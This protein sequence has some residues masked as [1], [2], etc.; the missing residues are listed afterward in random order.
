MLHDE[1]GRRYWAT[2][3]LSSLPYSM[4]SLTVFAERGTWWVAALRLPKLLRFPQIRSFFLNHK[5]VARSSGMSISEFLKMLLVLLGITHFSGTLWL[6]VARMERYYGLSGYWLVPWEEGGAS[7]LERYTDACFWA[8]STLTSIGFGDIAPTTAYERMFS[9]AVMVIGAS[10]YGAIFGTLV[11]LLSEENFKEVENQQKLERTKRWFQLRN[12]TPDLKMRIFT[13]YSLIRLKFSHLMES[14]F[15]E[16]LPLSL[17]TEILLFM[18]REMIPKVKMFELGDPAFLMGV[19][20]Y[21]RPKLYLAGDF[22]VKQGDFAEEMYFVRMGT[23]E[24]LASDDLTLLALLDEGCF[25]GEIGLFLTNTRTV[26]VT[27]RTASLISVIQGTELSLILDNFPEYKTFLL[28]IA[29]QRLETT[30]IEEIDL[31]DDIDDHEDDLRL[32]SSLFKD[33]S[34]LF[35]SDGAYNKSWIQS[36]ITV[37]ETQPRAEE[38]IIDIRSALYLL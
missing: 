11:L 38:Y 20:R 35:S 27:A 14:E 21:L 13:Y 24:V 9:L 30:H 28:K 31:T 5:I 18:H 6:A 3:L 8:T 2:M 32:Q 1:L 16:R 34:L 17:K 33:Y 4:F 29:H 15:L 23:V 25:F 12:L 36:F 19:V 37:R 7:Q 22:I 26:S 10:T